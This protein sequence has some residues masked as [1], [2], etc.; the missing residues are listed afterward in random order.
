MTQLKKTNLDVVEPILEE[1]K[2]QLGENKEEQEFFA[3]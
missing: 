2:L 1:E 3:T